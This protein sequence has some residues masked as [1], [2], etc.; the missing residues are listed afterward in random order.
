MPLLK[1]I[2]L[3]NLVI[4]AITQLL[5]YYFL[6]RPSLLNEGIAMSLPPVEFLYFI[7]TTLLINA[8][9]FIINDILDYEP[10]MMIDP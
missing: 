7:V 9:G 1:L 4:V 10:D 2:R 5:L 6:L 3:P 8:A